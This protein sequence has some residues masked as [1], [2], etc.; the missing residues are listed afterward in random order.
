MVPVR[1][2]LLDYGK[3]SGADVKKRV[4]RGFI[5]GGDRNSSNK[6]N[7]INDPAGKE[8]PAGS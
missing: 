3:D 2:M 6:A 4:R 1:R 7:T 5:A 8:A